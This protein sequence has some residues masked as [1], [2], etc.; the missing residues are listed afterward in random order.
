MSARTFYRKYLPLIQNC[1]QPFS[2]LLPERALQLKHKTSLCTIS[3]RYSVYLDQNDQCIHV[4]TVQSP[5][6]FNMWSGSRMFFGRFSTPTK[7]CPLQALSGIQITSHCASD[8]ASNRQTLSLLR[9]PLLCCDFFSS[10]PLVPGQYTL[11]CVQT[12]W[13]AENQPAVH[14]GGWGWGGGWNIGAAALFLI[15]SCCEALT[16]GEAAVPV[17]PQARPSLFCICQFH[18]V[19]GSHKEE[20]Q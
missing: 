8:E 16:R 1:G 19:E 3:C 18:G 5:S 9:V 10:L 20:L 17:L 14:P 7:I 13:V 12:L 11:Q 6:L 15:F 4:N 2:H